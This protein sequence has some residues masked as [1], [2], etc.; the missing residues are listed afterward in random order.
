[1]R[2]LPP[3]TENPDYVRLLGQSLVLHHITRRG[4]Q[5]KKQKNTRTQNKTKNASVRFKTPSPHPVEVVLKHIDG[6]GL[7]IVAPSVLKRDDVL[8][9][10]RRHGFHAPPL[11]PPN[12]SLPSPARLPR[13]WLALS[14][15]LS[16][17]FHTPPRLFQPPCSLGKKAFLRPSKTGRLTEGEEKRPTD[18]S[19]DRPTV[20]CAYELYPLSPALHA[21]VTLWKPL[22][23]GVFASVRPR[24]ASR[25]CP[26]FFRPSWVHSKSRLSSVRAI[27]RLNAGR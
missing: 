8:R 16:S 19:I 17:P 6:L 14:L 4:R 5:S 11:P 13:Q 23:S 21:L 10:A 20:R 25:P 7:D 2:I 3:L 12:P 26:L 27:D 18:R 24:L 9:L 22:P 15:C 1:M